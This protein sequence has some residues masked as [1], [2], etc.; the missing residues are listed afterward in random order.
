MGA[1]ALNGIIFLLCQQHRQQRQHPATISN[2]GE[3]EFLPSDSAC[4]AE[5][6]SFSHAIAVGDYGRNYFP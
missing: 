2:H 4:I 3:M 6:R 5:I 1:F